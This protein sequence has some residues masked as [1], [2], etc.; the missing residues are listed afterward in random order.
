MRK[1]VPRIMISAAGSSSGKTTVVTALLSLLVRKNYRVQSFKS[2]PDYIDPMYHSYITGRKTYHTDAFFSDGGTLN[3]M[4]ACKSA[5]ADICIIEGA[6]GYYDGI[7]KSS[8]ASAYTVSCCT[9]TPVILVVNP[10]GMGISAAALV[11]G[12]A[13]FRK[14][15]NIS[16]VILNRIKPGMYNYYREIIENE[17]GLAVYGYLPLIPEAGLESRHLGLVTADEVQNLSETAA[18]LGQT[19]EKTIDMEKLMM[20]ASGAPGIEYTVSDVKYEGRYVLGVAQDSAFCFYYD[21]NLEMLEAAGAEIKFFSPLNDE[22]LPEDADGL[23]FGGGY[24]ELRLRELSENRSFINDLRKKAETGIPVFAEC[25]GFMY[26]QKGIYD[27]N[28]DFYSTAGLLDGTSRLGDRLCRFGYI[29][30]TAEKDCVIAEK[31]MSIKAHEFHY[32][33]SECNGDT[34]T[35]AKPD[36]RSWKAVA[37]KGSIAAG[38]PHLYFPSNPDIVR[39]FSRKCVEYRNNGK[40]Q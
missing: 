4:I 13:E 38:F 15:S 40:L 20:T 24:P 19:A 35:A 18:V 7:G 34:F 29:T 32:S 3:A 23:Y 30:V 21:E 37:A 16:G 6:M 26:L 27:R 9:N 36:G 14:N 28:G 5:D 10:E 2:G 17:T 12:F 25:G 31:G 22:K 1:K 8:D 11:K 33:D 39:I